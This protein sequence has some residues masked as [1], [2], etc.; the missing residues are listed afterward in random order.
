M[1]RKISALLLAISLALAG[2]FAAPNILAAAAE[3]YYEGVP[4]AGAIPCEESAVIMEKQVLTLHA[5]SFPQPSAFAYTEYAANNFVT[6]EYTLYNPTSEDISLKMLYPRTDRTEWSNSDM[7]GSFSIKLNGNEIQTSLRHSYAGYFSR[8]LDIES[9]LMQLIGERPT[10]EFY[11]GDDLPVHDYKFFIN[12]PPQS[13]EG[14]ERKYLAFVLTFDCN[15]KKT[16]VMS[17][18]HMATDVVNGRVQAS[19]DVEEGSSEICLTVVGEDIDHLSYGV[20]VDRFA[21]Q[22]LELGAVTYQEVKSVFPEYAMRNYPEGSQISRKDWFNGF[23]QMLSKGTIG[24]Y[25]AYTRAEE[26]REESFMQWYEYSVPIPAGGRVTHTVSAPLYPTVNENRFQYDFLLS[27]GQYWDR[28]AAGY[29]EIE[30]NVETPY[31]FATGTLEFERRGERYTFRRDCL[32]IGELSFTL[33]ESEEAYLSGGRDYVYYDPISPSIRLAY[34]LLAV[35][36]GIT[37]VVA[38]VGIVIYRHSKKRTALS[39][40]EENP[41]SS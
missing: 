13:L 18:D 5:K 6:N 23:V 20:F 12:L 34:I 9:S 15:P 32:P 19:F 2:I 21:T 36:G 31:Y 37:L 41:R 25:F 24:G 28:F 39:E 16:R 35:L 17:S 26:L 10:D 27:S 3:P 30:I 40:R 1:G 38:T 33:T 29:G 11:F 8:N 7:G 14:I 4:A 22:K